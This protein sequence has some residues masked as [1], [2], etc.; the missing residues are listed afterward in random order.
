[1]LFSWTVAPFLLL[2]FFR[3]TLAVWEFAVGQGR[4][5]DLPDWMTCQ[6]VLKRLES[7]RERAKGNL[8][9]GIQGALTYALADDR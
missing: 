9:S 2:L 1:V 7:D 8:C 3:Q 5:G 4:S 6:E